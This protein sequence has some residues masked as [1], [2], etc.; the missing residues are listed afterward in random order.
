ML[1]SQAQASTG[2]QEPAASTSAATP[3]ACGRQITIDSGDLQSI[4]IRAAADKGAGNE[5]GQAGD[6]AERLVSRTPSVEDGELVLGQ[7]HQSPAE[8]QQKLGKSLDQILAEGKKGEQQ[9]QR[10]VTIEEVGHSVADGRTI[11]QPSVN[12]KD[13]PAARQPT[14]IMEL[15]R[16]PLQKVSSRQLIDKDDHQALPVKSSEQKPLPQ[17]IQLLGQDNVPAAARSGG[18]LKPTPNL[19]RPAALPVPLVAPAHRTAAFSSGGGASSASAARSTP[20]TMSAARV[21][22]AAPATAKP[23]AAMATSEPLLANPF[24]NLNFSALFPATR[25]ATESSSVRSSFQGGRAVLP[26]QHNRRPLVSMFGQPISSAPAAMQRTQISAGLAA[27]LPVPQPSMAVPHQ[28]SSLSWLTSQPQ[29]LGAALQKSPPTLPK[30]GGLAL[31]A[32]AKEPVQAAENSK[33]FKTGD[34]FLDSL[35]PSASSALSAPAAPAASVQ[36]SAAVTSSSNL[37]GPEHNVVSENTATPALAELLPTAS[38]RSLSDKQGSASGIAGQVGSVSSTDEAT[39]AALRSLEALQA[40]AKAALPGGNALPQEHA[41]DEAPKSGVSVPFADTFR[42]PAIGFSCSNSHTSTQLDSG[43]APV[44]ASTAKE[45]EAYAECGEQSLLAGQNTGSLAGEKATAESAS[46]SGS[47]VS[48]PQPAAAQKSAGPPR[49]GSLA[50]PTAN[51]QRQPAQAAPAGAAAAAVTETPSSATSGKAAVPAAAPLTAQPALEIG[52]LD[53][54]QDSTAG[55]STSQEQ[56]FVCSAL[57]VSIP[58]R[59]G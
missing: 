49:S 10:L 56:R 31:L 44:V 1:Q 3:L 25:L 15:G 50:F 40:I 36:V 5:L 9:A 54:A 29:A 33:I 47:K 17:H 53:P 39:A 16:S 30:S 23:A 21:T 37:V 52:R 22:S 27:V 12:G 45:G 32:A 11:G 19:A 14:D 41:R 55:H 42:H 7:L 6:A 18:P 59:L 35:L 28:E 46:L 43:A 57:R 24:K 58:Y 38:G 51:S 20:Q 34:A 26:I 4:T 2:H 48:V 8:V 13:S